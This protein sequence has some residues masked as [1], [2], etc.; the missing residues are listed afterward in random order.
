[1][2]SEANILISFIIPMYNSAKHIINTLDSLKDNTSES[3]EVILID[4]GS[5]DDTFKIVQNYICSNSLSYQLYYKS[6]GGSGSAR[7][8]G[9][10]KATGK[11]VWFV[12]S[13]DKI[14]TNSIKRL[15]NFIHFDYDLIMFDYVREI[16]GNKLSSNNC[17]NKLTFFDKVSVVKIVEMMS[18]TSFLN[19][20]CTKLF[21][22]DILRS[23]NNYFNEDLRHGEDRLF[24]LEFMSKVEKAIFI[25][26][27]LYIYIQNENS[28]THSFDIK[29]FE[30]MYVNYKNTKKIYE[31]WNIYDEKRSSFLLQR[32]FKSIIN[33]IRYLVQNKKINYHDFKNVINS[34]YN[35]L[36]LDFK[37][38]NKNRI[39][40]F[41]MF[42]F[43]KRCYLFVY[44]M[45]LIRLKKE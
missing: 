42:L 36:F 6:N 43:K 39:N 35:Q 34:T 2:K 23:G 19:S 41:L 32:H 30:N 11:Y 38:H 13:D 24:V 44:L 20:A 37:L 28:V 9:L 14:M 5:I 22:I 29:V 25:D 4:D 27:A 31:Y 7:N 26:E 17:F 45:L 15:L 18:E 21:K 10:K 40:D 16:N 12:D 8:Y 3:I 33:N 1:M